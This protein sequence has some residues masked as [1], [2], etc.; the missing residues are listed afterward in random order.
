M[1]MR[2]DR[3]GPAV[4]DLGEVLGRKDEVTKA[5]RTLESSPRPLGVVGEPGAGK[6]T[7]AG[8]IARRWAEAHP[9]GRLVVVDDLDE[10]WQLHDVIRE[11]LVAFGVAFDS[12]P[13]TLDE[14]IKHLRAVTT[15]DDIIVLDVAGRTDAVEE[16]ATHLAGARCVIAAERL[17][18]VRSMV[19][20][21]R[22]HPDDGRKMLAR[23]GPMEVADKVLARCAGV[24]LA[25]HLAAR[26]L[27][28]TDLSNHRE[29]VQFGL[30]IALQRVG[31][32]TGRSQATLLEQLRLL[33]DVGGSADPAIAAAVWGLDGAPMRDCLAAW[34]AA[35]VLDHA[36]SGELVLRPAVAQAAGARFRAPAGEEHL[37]SLVALVGRRASSDGA[38]PAD[39][40]W[41][42][43]HW[44]LVREAARRFAHIATSGVLA[45]IEHLRRCAEILN[46]W[47]DLRTLDEIAHAAAQRR[48][49]RSAQ[50]RALGQL[51]MDHFRR[52]AIDE[53]D[54]TAAEAVLQ[55]RAVGDPVLLAGQLIV[56]AKLSLAQRRFDRA[57]SG[58]EESVRLARSG[59][60]ADVEIDGL[61]AAAECYR[62]VRNVD[63]AIG[64]LSRVRHLLEG[65]PSVGEDPGPWAR[66][67][68]A[69]LDLDRPEEA[70][71]T[72]APLVRGSEGGDSDT[73]VA[74]E[75][76]GESL[77]RAGEPALAAQA[78]T[79]AV[80]AY[81]A[82]D[83][84]AGEGRSL[85][86]L[87]RLTQDEN[88]GRAVAHLHRALALAKRTGDLRHQVRIRYELG[89]AY[90]AAGDEQN[91]LDALDAAIG[92][93]QQLGDLRT[94][95]D[96]LAG[97]GRLL[98]RVGALSAAS[99]SLEEAHQLLESLG[100]GSQVAA[101]GRDLA[102]LLI[103]AGS[104]EAAIDLLER[105][106]AGSRDAHDQPNELL[107]LGLLAK[108]YDIAGRSDDAD[109]AR[110]RVRHLAMAMGHWRDATEAVLEA[111][112]RALAQ[113][114]DSAAVG[115][116]LLTL[117]E[118][119]KDGEAG[120]ASLLRLHWQAAV[121]AL[122]TRDR[123]GARIRLD[124]LIAL[125]DAADHDR[126]GTA[127]VRDVLI[128]A[129]QARADL[130]AAAGEA[131]AAMRDLEL[132]L[133]VARRADGA[134]P[135]D[136]DVRISLYR[137]LG[138][139]AVQIGDLRAAENYLR[140]ALDIGQRRLAHAGADPAVLREIEI[141]HTHLGDV[142]VTEGRLNEARMAF[143]RVIDLNLKRGVDDLQA[144]RA[145]TYVLTRLGDVAR[146][147]GDATEATRAYRRALS[148]AK[149]AVAGD[150]WDP[151]V[152]RAVI[153]VQL[154]LGDLASSLGDRQ[155]A[156][157][158]FNDSLATAERLA[159]RSG[160]E[161]LQEDLAASHQ[162]LAETY[163]AIGDLES[164]RRHYE[165]ALAVSERL[166]AAQP[167]DVSVARQLSIAHD[168]LGGL[169]GQLGEVNAA[170]EHLTRSLDIA[171]RIAAAQPDSL[172]L[173]RDLA[174]SY[175][176]LGQALALSGNEE[177]ARAHRSRALDIA[178]QLS[179]QHPASEDYRTLASAFERLD[180]GV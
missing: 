142:A 41:L 118:Q 10:R 93:A 1:A 106:V 156:V 177:E 149:Q 28:H 38:T 110:S 116:D 39:L 59:G 159:A 143:D 132:A 29:P 26:G 178:R 81:R 85:V 170:Q 100:A 19:Q 126:P 113:D 51:A 71:A 54:A 160:E 107:G 139:Q 114:G 21:S 90:A 111:V 162:R 127:E 13:P 152:Q 103:A 17:R 67:T 24:P 122:R 119:L 80:D 164:A 133:A 45:P 65:Q 121:A 83:D 161:I 18:R 55:A 141:V 105:V 175:A 32:D 172:L 48:G 31:T 176:N 70:V 174:I 16:A 57:I 137:L 129:H 150:P 131:G 69:Y 158:R 128:A 168:G 33:A 157:S 6:S 14:Q 123:R 138:E 77:R 148:Y 163:R 89:I 147:G 44:P 25:L 115:R 102:D 95:A 64:A 4:L 8:L 88:P 167:D 46:R 61:L 144:H 9:G 153:A 5:L 74:L 154:R 101:V 79:R 108:V 52:G 169:F 165:S 23:F 92:T 34:E 30:D 146:L 53:A 73:A 166:A 20:A 180:G 173:R 117:V 2:A 86:G 104:A 68:R 151:A 135:E 125:A 15:P 171:E 47:E 78:L 56:A 124:Q 134:R 35:G 179:E 60:D 12:L 62:H 87:A 40:V 50:A 136:L 140:S 75:L 97:R 82:S 58:L 22:L 72:L 109:W 37:A 3:R 76:I 66:L 27:T 99:K 112:P 91:A 145:L 84:P 36:A 11:L 130:S 63:D 94:V 120:N 98:A 96:A 42:D 155:E 43:R 7:L 49:D